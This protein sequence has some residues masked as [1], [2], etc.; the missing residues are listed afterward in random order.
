VR[1]N[2]RRVRPVGC[3]QGSPTRSSRRCRSTEK[4]IEAVALKCPD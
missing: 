4:Q 2:P 1:P 3:G